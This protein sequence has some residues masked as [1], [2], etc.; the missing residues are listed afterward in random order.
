MGIAF[1]DS[2]QKLT[3][4]LQ[5]KKSTV[6][7]KLFEIFPRKVDLRPEKSKIAENSQINLFCVLP[8]KNRPKS[9]KLS[10]TTIRKLSDIRAF[11]RGIRNR[12]PISERNPRMGAL[13]LRGEASVEWRTQTLHPTPH[14]LH[15]TPYTL[16][17]TPHTLHPTLYTPHPKPYTLHPTPYTLNP[18]P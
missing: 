16:H 4:P 18:Q 2:W 3:T 9:R 1:S 7:L 6:C 10:E 13:H 17:P 5:E 8:P 14:T 12:Y 15:P 11:E